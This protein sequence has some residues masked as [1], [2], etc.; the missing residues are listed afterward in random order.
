MS[1]GHFNYAQYNFVMIAEEIEQ[2]IEKNDC[3]DKNQW[4]DVIGNHYSRETMREFDKAVSLLKE[5]Y[6]YVQR[7]DWLVSGDDGED[8][9]HRRLAN[10]LSKVKD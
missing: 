4:G 9:F 8:S 10:E 1:G 5:A 7:I 6:V 3:N 2:L